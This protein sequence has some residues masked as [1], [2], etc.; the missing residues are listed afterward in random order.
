MTQ[1]FQNGLVIPVTLVKAEPCLI[2]QIKSKDGKDCYDAIQIGSEKKKRKIKKSAKGK[3]LKHLKE[4]RSQEEY[5]QGDEITLSVF[6][7]GDKVKVSAISKGKGF[8]GAV[9]K[10]G[11]HGRNATHGTKHEERTLGSVGSTGPARVFKGKKMPGRMGSERKT[12][13][14]LEIIKIDQ[15]NNIIGIKGAV[16]GKRGTLVEI[17]CQK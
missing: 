12:I 11:F 2:T 1:I 8:Q 14:N 9:K 10:W 5:N 17:V 7:T 15:E 6:K 4:F 16:P 3:E 13:K